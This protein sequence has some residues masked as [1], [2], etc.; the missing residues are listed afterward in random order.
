[1]IDV[2]G[3]KLEPVADTTGEVTYAV[4]V[5]GNPL[6]RVSFVKFY[7]PEGK[8]L[9]TYLALWAGATLC[10]IDRRRGTMRCIERDDETR[11]VSVFESA[12]IVEGELSVDLFDP[13]SGTTSATYS[14]SDVILSCS[15]DGDLVRV[16]GD[17]GISVT[18][19]PRRSL[20]VV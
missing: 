10:V 2:P 5:N 12:W 11:G 6:G 3:L 1:M 15:I 7:E 13:E 18:L 20:R 17:D 19:D 8:A 16:E 4:I 14:H 9:G